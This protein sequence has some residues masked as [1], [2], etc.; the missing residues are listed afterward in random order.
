MDQYEAVFQVLNRG[1]RMTLE[2][3]AKAVSKLTGRTALVSSM[4]VQICLLRRA[5]ANIVTTRAAD[6]KDGLARYV[7]PK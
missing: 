6:T 2:A 3:L 7:I 1:K 4:N 5:G